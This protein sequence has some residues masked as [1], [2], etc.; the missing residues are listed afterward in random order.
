[1][2]HYHD[3][4]NRHDLI[5]VPTVTLRAAIAMIIAKEDLYLS[6]STMMVVRIGMKEIRCLMLILDG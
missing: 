6:M 1:M 5:L 4:V 3:A 2:S